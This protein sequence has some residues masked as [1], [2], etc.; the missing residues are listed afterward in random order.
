MIKAI[1]DVFIYLFTRAFP[2]LLL[3]FWATI[4]FLLAL[5]SVWY[6]IFKGLELKF[7]NLSPKLR[8]WISIILT[9]IVIYGF[10]YFPDFIETAHEMASYRRV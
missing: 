4:C 6:C 2:A 9:F 10:V 1:A 8:I 7:S 3:G 5:F